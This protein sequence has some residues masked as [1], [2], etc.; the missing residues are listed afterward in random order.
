MIGLFS[1]LR[2]NFSFKAHVIALISVLALTTGIGMA[3]ESAPNKTILIIESYH[4]G[5]LWS[6]G[7]REEIVRAFSDSF[8]IEYFRMDTKRLLPEKHQMMADMAWEKYREVNPVM[9]FLGDDAALKFL[10]PRLSKTETPVIYLGIN[11]NPR[12]YIDVANSKNITGVLERPLLKAN[13]SVIRGI[14]PNAKRAL[15]L[16][17]DDLTSKVIFKE[18]FSGKDRHIL[19]GITADIKLIGSLS[20]WRQ[21]V[22]EAHKSGYD[23]VIVGLYHTLRDE[24]GKNA[25]S[26]DVIRWTSSNSSVPLF[27]FWE[28]SIGSDKAMGGFVISSV[29]QGRAAVEIARRI[30]SG[31]TPHSIYPV[32]A[33]KGKFV[34]SRGQLVKK[35][36]KLPDFLRIRAV[37]I[38]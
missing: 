17:D 37:L 31:A 1:V 14:Y 7:Y 12:D 38:D 3:G 6:T 11:N 8:K 21:N 25:D 34:F 9:V 22:L 23:T 27:G 19:E 26:E 5:Y 13:F 18:T 20:D 36:V 10:G 24:S 28:F 29:E 15:I 32:T 30:V 33:E 16:F 35:G 2:K 4:E